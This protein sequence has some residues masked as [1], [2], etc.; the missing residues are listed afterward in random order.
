MLR[1]FGE[2]C[3]I[4]RLRD[5]RHAIR[6]INSEYDNLSIIYSMHFF[7]SIYKSLI[8]INTK[9]ESFVY[10]PK[11]YNYKEYFDNKDTIIC[12]LF[13][14]SKMNRNNYIS[15]HDSL[16]DYMLDSPRFVNTFS[17]NIDR[18]IVVSA[19]REKKNLLNWKTFFQGNYI[20]Y[21]HYETNNTKQ[22]K[23]REFN[24]LKEFNDWLSFK[25]GDE[26]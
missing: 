9:N 12:S 8:I 15:G 21:I 25:F 19:A 4:D 13:N 7:A 1:K 17:L 2:K 20:I 14:L 6:N 24:S 18:I 23:S 26:G 10:E 3:N 5:I 16:I 22:Y 11:P